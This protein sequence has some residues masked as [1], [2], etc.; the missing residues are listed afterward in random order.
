MGDWRRE[1]GDWRRRWEKGDGRQERGDG[2]QETGD[3][4]QETGEGFSDVVS[5]KFR[6][7]G[8][9]RGGDIVKFLRT[10]IGNKEI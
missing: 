5:E 10:I 1:M 3:R 9:S 4:I 2:R 6:P 8:C 7:C